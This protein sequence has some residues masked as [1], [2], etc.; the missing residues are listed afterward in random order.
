MGGE[1]TRRVGRYTHCLLVY[2]P[3]AHQGFMR[4]L[5]CGRHPALAHHSRSTSA[6]YIRSHLHTQAF[7]SL[8]AARLTSVAAIIKKNLGRKE[9]R[10]RPNRQSIKAAI[11]TAMTTSLESSNHLNHTDGLGDRD[12]YGLVPGLGVVPLKLLHKIAPNGSHYLKVTE[13]F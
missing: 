1:R 7:A 5:Q 9:K 3:Q 11:D 8:Y 12:Q 6:E 13:V 10:G 2:T 4:S